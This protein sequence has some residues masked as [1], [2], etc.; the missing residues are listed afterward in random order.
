MKSPTIV[1]LSAL[2]CASLASPAFAQDSIPTAPAASPVS[3]YPAKGM[4]PN[5]KMLHIGI[6]VRD[7]EAAREH[8]ATFLGTETK[9]NIVMANG[10]ADNPTEFRGHPSTAKAKLVFFN[11][12]NLQVELIEPIGDEPSSWKEFLDAKGEGVHHIGF[13]VKGMGEQ[14]LDEYARA[15][16]P[17]AQHG[18]WDGGEYGYMDTD[19]SLGVIVELLEMYP[20]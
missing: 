16:Q 11:L 20:K 10:H 1:L 2:L 3:D 15:G 4:I 14:Y 18:G 17:V 7:I 19:K 9:P 5:T 6:V 8:W 13:R 12:E